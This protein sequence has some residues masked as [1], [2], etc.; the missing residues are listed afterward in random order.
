MFNLNSCTL[1]NNILIIDNR[2][3]RFLWTSSSFS[4]FNLIKTIKKISQIKNL[5]TRPFCRRETR[6]VNIDKITNKCLKKKKNTVLLQIFVD[7]T[8]FKLNDNFGEKTNALNIDGNIYTYICTQLYNRSGFQR[9]RHFFD[10]YLSR[11]FVCV[12][13][14][15]N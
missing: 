2:F 7:L 4:V 15:A 12:K 3:R 13:Y 8:I 6:R 5:I 14:N 9:I 1:I 10:R 11:I